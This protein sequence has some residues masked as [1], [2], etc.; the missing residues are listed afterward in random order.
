MDQKPLKIMFFLSLLISL[1][2]LW[3]HHLM[4]YLKNFI[5]LFHEICHALA[6][7]LTGGV[8]EKIS[9]HGNESGETIALPSKM[10]G[11]FVFIVSA[12]YLGSS[13]FGGLLL[14]RGFSGKYEKHSLLILAFTIL[15]IT[16][17]FSESG[18]LA[19]S[20]GVLWGALFL[21]P[22][23]FSRQISS[24]ALVFLGTSV[25]L[26]SIYD[27]F[28]FAHRIENTDAGILANWILNTNQGKGTPQNSVIFLSYLIGVIWS[29]IS[30]L[31]VYLSIQKTFRHAAPAPE[32]D[33][34][35]AEKFPGEV[36]P[37]IV[38]WFLSRGM[39]LNGKPLPP[40]L[41]S[42]ISKQG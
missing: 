15:F 1:I 40:E 13:M 35:D 16:F 33:I 26:Y 9:I 6:A 2:T 34:H 10:K 14:H 38:D 4:G 20:T 19:Y 8:V 25:S 3:D 11:S 5:V 27:L 18:N 12:G 7:L 22:G 37:E 32:P 21:L 31:I 30:L 42:D 36:T 41:I 28:D 23:L 17:K 39:D 24:L 29:L